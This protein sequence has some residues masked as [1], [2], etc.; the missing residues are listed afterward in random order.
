MLAGSDARYSPPQIQ[1]M[2][3]PTPCI[4]ISIVFSLSTANA[5][6]QTRETSPTVVHSPGV[7]GDLRLHEF[8][9]ATFGNTRLLRVLVPD[10]YDLP[11]N[12]ARHYP[13]LYLADGQN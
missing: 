7:V 10:G 4:M 12:R 1:R 3:R 8:T 6:A 13:I 11:A 5:R 2:R 9:S